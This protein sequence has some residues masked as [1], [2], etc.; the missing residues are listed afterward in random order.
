MHDIHPSMNNTSNIEVRDDNQC[1][2]AF[3]S[4]EHHNIETNTRDNIE[5]EPHIID[6]STQHQ[7]STTFSNQ[8]TQEVEYNEQTVHN[9]TNEINSTISFGSKKPSSSTT[10]FV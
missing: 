6:T 2:Y 7:S 8:I 5:N 10:Y 4:S 9:N 1:D 3:S